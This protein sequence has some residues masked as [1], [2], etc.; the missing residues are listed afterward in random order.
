MKKNNL[1]TVIILTSIMILAGSCRYKEGPAI[2]FRSVLSRL[3]GQYHVKKMTIDDA[4]Y[5]QE[6]KDSFNCD[7]MF[8]YDDNLFLLD[9]YGSSSNEIDFAGQYTLEHCSKVIQL[10]IGQGDSIHGYGPFKRNTTSIWDIVKLTNSEIILEGDYQN[11]SYR[12]E[13]EEFE[14]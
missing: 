4:D 3:E 10:C 5:T 6:Y 7:F 1:I 12:I 9:N 14:Y 8:Y 2:S 11:K 13:L